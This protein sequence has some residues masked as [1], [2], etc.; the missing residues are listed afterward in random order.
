MLSFHLSNVGYAASN[1]APWMSRQGTVPTGMKG[2]GADDLVSSLRDS[3]RLLPVIQVLV[4]R[5]SLRQ[6]GS[7]AREQSSVKSNA[8]EYETCVSDDPFTISKKRKSASRAVYAP[9][10]SRQWLTS[11]P[12]KRDEPDDN[13]PCL[14][15]DKAQNASKNLI[16]K[17]SSLIAQ[18]EESA[19]PGSLNPTILAEETKPAP[20][21]VGNFFQ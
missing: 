20:S 6:I 8:K 3:T 13:P 5:L 7:D 21:R 14:N 9:L 4:G 18:V 11:P 15:N 17:S 12:T 1:S 2:L 19:K 10:V 16:H